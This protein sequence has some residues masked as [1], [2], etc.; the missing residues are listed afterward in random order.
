MAVAEALETPQTVQM[1]RDKFVELRGKY[2]VNSDSV[3]D[4]L[5]ALGYDA[6]PTVRTLKGVT[7]AVIVEATMII[8][9]V[10]PPELYT[11][12]YPGS[13]GWRVLI[14]ISKG[15]VSVTHM[16]REE[17]QAS[18]TSPDYF[19]I[20]WH[21]TVVLDGRAEAVQSA[22][23]RIV[24]L[25]VNEKAPKARRDLIRRTFCGGSLRLY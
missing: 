23:L 17:A 18:P 1:L 22:S 20:E 16:R 8:K 9:S 25:W 14:S 13:D 12:D 21:Q 24:D 7:Q 19:W 6:S 10:Q 15:A 5:E 2:T 3:D 11:K 4:V